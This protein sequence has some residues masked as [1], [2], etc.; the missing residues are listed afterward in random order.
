MSEA[1][2]PGGRRVR[3]A[4]PAR[5]GRSPSGGRGCRPRR[6]TRWSARPSGTPR[7]ASCLNAVHR[8]E[9]VRVDDVRDADDRPVAHECAL[10]CGLASATCW[11]GRLCVG[12]SSRRFRSHASRSRSQP[13]LG[14]RAVVLGVS[15]P[16]AG[17]GGVHPV[18][19]GA[20]EGPHVVERPDDGLLDA[21]DLLDGQEAVRDPVQ[22]DD[23]GVGGVDLA[24]RGGCR[25]GP[26]SATSRRVSA[27]VARA[28][29]RVRWRSGIGR[30]ARS[31][32]TSGCPP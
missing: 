12:A 13:G 30:R 25:T 6:G 31:S 22:V 2:G 9:H 15:G 26:V 28:V 1:G 29:D 4:G 17:V 32:E 18:V 10:L 14:R 16:P 11:P 27:A 7:T 20:A 8:G 24:A 3:P 5:A 21:A 23:V 19:L